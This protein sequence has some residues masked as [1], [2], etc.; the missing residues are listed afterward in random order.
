MKGQVIAH[1]FNK[2]VWVRDSTG[3]EFA[4][5]LNHDRNVQSKED[6]SEIEQK[7]CMNLNAVLGDS[8]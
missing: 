2:M 1:E 7:S 6:L 5:Y 3:S 4:C 8:W